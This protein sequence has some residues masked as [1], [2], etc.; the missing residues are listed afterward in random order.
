MIIDWHNPL[1]VTEV[2]PGAPV[3]VRP[4]APMLAVPFTPICVELVSP[5]CNTGS[6]GLIFIDPSL[7]I[8]WRLVIL[9]LVGFE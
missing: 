8:I 2:F 5:G 7:V 4:D 6:G 1:T 9:W 3:G